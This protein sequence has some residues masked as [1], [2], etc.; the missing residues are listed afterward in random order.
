LARLIPHLEVSAPLGL[1]GSLGALGVLPGAVAL[2]AG[3]VIA[4]LLLTRRLRRRSAPIPPGESELL[5]LYERVQRRLERRRAPPETPLEYRGAIRAGAL[6]D[7]LG[8][9]T[10]AVNEGAYGG[11]W[12]QPR[13]VRE[14]SDRLS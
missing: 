14:I 3:C 8:E 11:R 7:V 2:V 6:G 10:D 4:I 13:Q 5:R 1:L 12:P 9:L